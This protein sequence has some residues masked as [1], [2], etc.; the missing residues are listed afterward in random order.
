M[1]EAETRSKRLC[2]GVIVGAHG[3]RGLVRIKSFTAD[4]AAVGAYGA[5]E[6]KAG[7]R[8]FD[9]RITGQAKGVVLARIGGVDDRDAA[10][11]LKGT[12]LWVARA[13]LP[14][15]EDA[16]EF[17]H[18]DLIGLAAE[19]R[20]GQAV[21]SVIAVHTFGETDVLEVAPAAGGET[22]MVPFTKAS[23][24]EVDVAGGRVVV[25]PPAEIEPG[26]E[27]GAGGLDE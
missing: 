24:P 21:G 6:D 10:E 25:D 14:A 3:V 15:P 11:A 2:L 1:A 23:V 17:Y 13:A 9:V 27:G 18:A 26:P 7:E 16:E 12:G 19:D 5:L 22:L 4:P 8:R 20:Q